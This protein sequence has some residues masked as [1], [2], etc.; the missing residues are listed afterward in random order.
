[1]N[2]KCSCCII[3]LHFTVTIVICNSLLIILWFTLYC[4]SVVFPSEPDE[5]DREEIDTESSSSSSYS[6]MSEEMEDESEEEMEEDGDGDEEG[7]AVEGEDD[8]NFIEDDYDDYDGEWKGYSSSSSSHGMEEED[9]EQEEEEIDDES[10]RELST[11]GPA[12]KPNSR[13]S[14]CATR[15]LLSK[16][17]EQVKRGLRV[18]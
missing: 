10:D 5:R 13:K 8:S 6:S 11:V 14:K 17:K 18:T 16:K 3:S 15:N 1:M 9:D 7:K 12:T 2:F 4:A